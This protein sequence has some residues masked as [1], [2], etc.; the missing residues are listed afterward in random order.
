MSE[1]E[2]FR[3]MD[4]EDEIQI[5]N[6]ENL[7]N[8][9]VYDVHGKQMLSYA[10][11]KCIFQEWIKQQEI[12]VEIIHDHSSCQLEKDG[13]DK[14]SWVWRAQVTVR[15]TRIANGQIFETQGQ[16]ECMYMQN[17]RYDPFGKTKA[18]SKAERNAIRKQIPE[19]QITHAL[20]SM[21]PKSVKV[22]KKTEPQQESRQTPLPPKQV[23]GPPVGEIM[24]EI[25]AELAQLGY[26][27]DAPR[28]NFDAK[29]LVIKL[30][31]GKA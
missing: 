21:D 20:N 16:Q 30:K 22:L 19:A 10:G 8:A 7:N 17:G 6:D 25:Q 1:I 28:N 23:N 12:S 15:T 18:F 14:A 26:K 24:P 27:G 5:I 9:L 13:E 4:S 11:V 3:L 29:Q 31:E 2:P